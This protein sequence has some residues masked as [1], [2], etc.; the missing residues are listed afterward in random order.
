MRV[1]SRPRSLPATGI[2]IN[3]LLN[4]MH[5]FKWLFPR[6]YGVFMQEVQGLQ[7]Y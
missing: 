6:K 2:L 1:H 4:V 7:T 5:G 3:F